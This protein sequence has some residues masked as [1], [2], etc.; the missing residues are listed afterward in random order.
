MNLHNLISLRHCFLCITPL[1]KTF[2]VSLLLIVNPDLLMFIR[3]WAQ[4]VLLY[5]ACVGLFTRLT[6]SY[7]VPTGCPRRDSYRGPSVNKA[8]RVSPRCLFSWEG[9]ETVSQLTYEYF[10]FNTFEIVNIRKKPGFC[11][12]PSFPVIFFF[13]T[14]FCLLQDRQGGLDCKFCH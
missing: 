12:P 13:I 4:W 10:T 8:G 2:Q 14:I 6:D 11:W 3:S 5:S 9:R 7:W 1:L